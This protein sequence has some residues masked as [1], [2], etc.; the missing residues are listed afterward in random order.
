MRSQFLCVF[1]VVF[2]VAVQG[3]N[4]RPIIG[5][6]A[7]PPDASLFL[8]KADLQNGSPPNA[9][10]NTQQ[11]VASYVKWL[12]SGGAR[13]VPVLYLPQRRKKRKGG[14]KR[15]KGEKV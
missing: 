2:V 13:I 1:F 11:I 3:Q 6:L 8:G 12:E 5:I 9:F 14:E 10:N 15:G 7:Q 4:L